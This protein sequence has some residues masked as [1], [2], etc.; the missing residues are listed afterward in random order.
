MPNNCIPIWT[1]IT[2]E[3]NSNLIDILLDGRSGMFYSY[4][5]P[6]SEITKKSKPFELTFFSSITSQPKIYL[7][8]QYS[9]SAPWKPEQTKW[10]HLLPQWRFYDIDDNVVDYIEPEYTYVYSG[11]SIIGITGVGEFRYADDLPTDENCPLYIWATFDVE[12]MPVTYDLEKQT[13]PGYSNSLVVLGLPYHI[14]GQNPSRLEITRNGEDPFLNPRWKDIVFPYVITIHGDLLDGICD[15]IGSPVLFDYPQSNNIGASAGNE[16]NR[17][18]SHFTAPSTYSAFAPSSQEWDPEVQYFQRYDEEDLHIGGFVKG[19]TTSFI[20]SENAVITADVNVQYRPWYREYP[21]VWIS[22]PENRNMNIFSLYEKRGS[23]CET[24][25]ESDFIVPGPHGGQ[26]NITQTNFLTS[27]FMA[28]DVPYVTAQPD[29]MALTGFGGIFG[30]A[31]DPCYDA[32]VTDSELDAI[33][34]FSPQGDILKSIYLKQVPEIAA[35]NPTMTGD[36]IGLSPVGISLDKQSNFWVTLFDFVST[37]KFD[38][39]GNFLFAAQPNNAE[40]PEWLE[41]PSLKGPQVDTDTNNDAWVTYSNYPSSMIVKY[42]SS[43]GYSLVETA[44]QPA[45]ATPIDILVDGADNSVWITNAFSHHMSGTNGILLSTWELPYYP[46]YLTID[47]DKN[48]WFVYGYNMVGKLNSMSTDVSSFICS[49]DQFISIYGSDQPDPQWFD[50]EER[51]DYESLQGIACDTRNRIWVINSLENRV[52]VVDAETTDF[53]NDP[54]YMSF[55]V[56]PNADISWNNDTGQVIQQYEAHSPWFKSAQAFGDWTGYRWLQK[57]HPYTTTTDLITATLSATSN[58]F[59]ILPP[60]YYCIRRF[61]ESWDATTQVRD[62]A[63]AEHVHSFHNFWENVLGNMIGGLECEQQSLGRQSYERIANFV[64]NHVDVDTT[65]MRPL[66]NI[67]KQTDVPIDNYDFYYPPELRR[68]M[69][70][71]SVPHQKLWGARCKCNRH[72]GKNEVC[73]VCNHIHGLNRGKQLD[74]ATYM[75][76]ADIPVVV[77]FAFGTEY[78]IIKPVDLNSSIVYPLSSA[79]TLS[80]LPS[81]EYWRYKWYEYIPTYCNTQVEGIINWDDPYT[82]LKESQSAI[83]DWYGDNGLVEKIITYELYRGLGY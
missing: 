47:R 35:L 76:S 38:I 71:A 59:Q 11:S 34:K 44:I 33:Y 63:L 75:V 69:D 8:S 50:M 60:A 42:R 9:N 29:P 32:W 39:D 7:Y 25:E 79:P 74:F 2:K 37:L 57:Y 55:L 82:T 58:E 72:F 17:G 13:L 43:D 31:A 41:N 68:F 22:N 48:I 54:R 23:E 70:I 20:S 67:A 27:N 10:G 5:A 49:A 78:K 61:N 4:I 62:Y 45:S 19:S 18:F 66:Y 83:E 21:Y 51:L 64:K 81:S 15:D 40:P 3:W 56:A 36:S 26:I 24:H 30:I 14:N 16:I 80:W 46:S 53:N 28:F 52:Y 73:E 6:P 12:N 77:K 1:P 65:T